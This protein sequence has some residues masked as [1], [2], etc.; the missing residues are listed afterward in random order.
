MKKIGITGQ[1][2][3]VGYHLYQ[4]IKLFK[5]EFTLIDFERSFFENDA[6]LDGFVEQCDVIVHL[7]ALNRHNDQE[8]IYETNTNLVKKLVA[9]LKRT[10]SQAHI[11]ISSS[12]Q[13]ERDNLYGK[14]KKESRLMLSN[15]ANEAK[16]RLTGLVIPNVYGPFGHPFYNSVIATFCHQIARDETPK[17]EVDGDLKLIYVGD[18]ISEIINSL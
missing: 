16:G 2:G 4:T 9:S 10:K 1:K 5:D 6:S 13:E 12:T 7:A 15:W 3:F 14:S 11:I 17:I 8:V 18:L